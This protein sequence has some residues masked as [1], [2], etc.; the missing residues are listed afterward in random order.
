MKVSHHGAGVG[1]VEKI[2]HWAMAAGDKNGV[3]L[4]QARCDG[5]GDT[6]WIFEASQAVAEFQIVLTWRILSEIG[7]LRLLRT[8]TVS[9]RIGDQD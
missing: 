6:S 9:F 3:I 1:I 7:I 5:I 4:I 2:H 8:K